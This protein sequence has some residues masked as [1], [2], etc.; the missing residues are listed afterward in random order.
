MDVT[1]INLKSKPTQ[2][3]LQMGTTEKPQNMYKGITVPADS[4]SKHK[5]A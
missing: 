2:K 4:S 3:V 1:I 5:D